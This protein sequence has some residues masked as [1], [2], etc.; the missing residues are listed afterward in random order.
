MLYACEAWAETIKGNFDDVTLLTKNK[1]EKFQIKTYKNLLGVSR[2]TSN[3]SILLELGRYPITSYMHYQT[4][5]YFF[6]RLSTI[7]NDRLLHEAYNL[8]KEKIH[9]R[10][11]GF[12]NY[13][14]NTL[15]RIGISNIRIKQFA[16]DN[17]PLLYKP[18]INRNI[19]K[20]F[21]DIFMQNALTNIQNNNKLIF[22][23]S[24]KDSYTTE[25]YL[26]IKD[27]QNRIT[28]Y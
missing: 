3:I 25:N 12:I 2:T 8:E 1:L 22:L 13:M 28:I 5:K 23:N 9:T 6:T 19:L 4:V 11:K 16:Y 20:R 17:N 10:E 14:T 18:T 24:L 27:F 15:N 7:K 26:K 21:H